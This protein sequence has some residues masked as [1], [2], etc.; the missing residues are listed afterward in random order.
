MI[1]HY[2]CEH[3]G[4]VGSYKQKAGRQDRYEELLRI[5]Q[6]FKV[7]IEN[8]Q[9]RET[10]LKNDFDALKEELKSTFAETAGKTA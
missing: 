4:F 6:H 3:C 7:E 2:E 1:R 10:R 9:L 8:A 5:V